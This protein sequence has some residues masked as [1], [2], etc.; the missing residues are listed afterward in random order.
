MTARLATLISALV[1]IVIAAAPQAPKAQPGRHVGPPA[2]A[3]A[4]HWD[5]SPALREMPRRVPQ[6]GVMREAPRI[7]Q[8]VGPKSFDPIVQSSPAPQ[9]VPPPSL[10]FEGV[11]NLNG[12][13]PPDTNGAVGPNHYVQWVNLSFAVYLRGAAGST[14]S[15]IYG[16]VAGTTLWTGFGGACETANNGDPVVR[17]DRLADRWVLSQLALPNSFLGLYLAPFYQCIAVSATPDPTG[18]YYRYQYSFNKLNDYPKFGVWPDAY[19]MTMNQFSPP[20]LSFAGEGVLAFDRASMLAGQPAGMISFDL[21]SVDMNLANMLPSDFDGPPPPAGA[22]NYYMQVD[23]DAWGYAPDQ[24]QLWKFHVDWTTPSNSSFTHAVSLPTAA[25]DSSLCGG[26]SNCV[27]QP[28]TTVTLDTLSDR[29]MYRLQYRNFGDHESLVV[30]HTV[31]VDGTD[32]AGVRWYEIRDPNGTPV[33]Y[34][35]GTYAPDSDHRWMGSAALDSAGNLALGFSVSSA[36]LYP[37]IRYAARLATDPLGTLA[38]GETTLIAGSGSQTNSSGR[39]GDYSMMTVDPRDDCT[40]WYTQEYYAAT[41]DAGWQTRIGTFAL[42][43]CTPTQ[44]TGTQVTVAATIATANAAG[45]TNGQFT[46]SRTGDTTAPLTVAYTVAGTATP[47]T[48][49][50]PLD[51]TITIPAGAASATIP[52]VA[53]A[54]LVY[55][56]NKTVM[57]TLTAGANYAVASPATALVT[58][59]SAVLPADLVVSALTVPAVGGAN[60]AVVVNDTTKNQGGGPAPSSTTTFYLSK[61]LV[62]GADDTLLGSRTVAA[63]ASGASDSGPTTLTI[64]AGT[65]TGNYFIIAN[66]DGTGAVT[67]SQENNNTKWASISI[68]PDLTVTALTASATGAAGGT[69]VVSDTVTNRGG[70]TAGASTVAYYLSTNLAVDAGDGLLGARAVPDLAA[71]ASNSATTTVTVPA[72][73]AAGVYYVLAVADSANAVV[74]TSETNNVKASMAVRIGADLIVSA[75]TAPT[76]AGAGGA[77]VIT[78]T[79]ANQ[80]AGDA[81]ASNTAFYLSSNLTIDAGD[82][83]LGERPVPALAAGASSSATTSFAI[84]A[85]TPTGSYYVIASADNDNQVIEST[86]TNNTRAS[87]QVRVGP[88]LVETGTT[89]S[90]IGGAGGTIVVGDTAKNQGG[91]EAGPSTTAFYLSTSA[92]FSSSAV[93]IGSR[94]VPALAAGATNVASTTVTLPTGL[95]TGTYFVFAAA[96]ADNAVTETLETNNTSFGVAVRVGPDLTMTAL[97]VPSSFTAGVMTTV[98]STVLNQGGGAAPA[99]TV[100]FYLSTNLTLDAS[101]VVVGSRTAAALAAGQSDAGPAVIL[102]PTGTAPGSYY[103]IGVADDGNAVIETNETN[104]TRA[105]FIVVKAGAGQ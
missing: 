52:V 73:T 23:D 82:V 97:S 32:H 92:V 43:P 105:V 65:A 83:L 4:D 91:G 19:Y 85:A 20:L 69:M 72:G 64:P 66:A 31:D 74:E 94:T 56:P 58:I 36:S 79:T 35:Q 81:P 60:A 42:P 9:L 40:F 53:I 68:G 7:R 37:T 57:L 11:G 28:G 38:Q 95:A 71:G 80:G 100:R 39:W 5:K 21:S 63:L 41:S 12:V 6:P 18:P 22:P 75:V 86:E 77:V 59:V 88:D 17:Y 46:V 50:V 10:A 45:P 89:A 54:N 61:D 98:S 34:Q 26:S 47:G 27:P 102:V 1:A 33:I 101:D 2:F 13:L 49:Y 67:E 24:L 90:S 70:G 44:T 51:G 16:P 87:A 30:N 76:I 93:R 84:P 29:L 3:K 78:D 55:Q 25:F 15:L 48:D 96:D 104:N 8:T 99:T 14:P 103:L 62:L